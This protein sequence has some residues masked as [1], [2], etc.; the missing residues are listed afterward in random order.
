MQGRR[1]VDSVR[2]TNRLLSYDRNVN[3]LNHMPDGTHVLCTVNEVDH[4]VT[5]QR[6]D[7]DEEGKLRFEPMLTC[8]R[9]G[10]PM[11]SNW[12]AG[13]FDFL[14]DNRNRDGSYDL[15]LGAGYPYEEGAR[16]YLIPDVIPSSKE[17]G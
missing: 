11:F 1:F 10:A 14:P 9:Q 12:Q 3:T 8:D 6:V 4:S 13:E 17:A 7:V 16:L 5:F 2:V 15:L